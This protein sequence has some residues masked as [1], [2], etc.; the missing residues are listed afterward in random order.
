MKLELV[1]V[2][3]ATNDVVFMEDIIVF[4]DKSSRALRTMSYTLHEMIPDICP[5]WVQKEHAVIL[6]K[7]F[8]G[9]AFVDKRHV[10]LVIASMR[11]ECAVLR[12]GFKNKKWW[13][14]DNAM[15]YC[16]DYAIKILEQYRD[17]TDPEVYLLTF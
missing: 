7:Y 17:T 4:L 13:D 6:S 9:H 10:G 5:S 15:K 12:E 2:L 16:I 14:E 11:T 3:P 1:K 8:S